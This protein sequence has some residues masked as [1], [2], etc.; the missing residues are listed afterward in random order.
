MYASIRVII[1][2]LCI[3]VLSSVSTA[4]PYWFLGDLIVDT[5]TEDAYAGL[6][7]IC[8]EASEISECISY[9]ESMLP[10][11]CQLVF[12]DITKSLI[13]NIHKSFL[14]NFYN[15]IRRDN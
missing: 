8:T 6:W 10:V 13:Q 7:E 14:F 5:F 4:I 9:T 11:G 15:I 3:T 1:A 12:I 2:I